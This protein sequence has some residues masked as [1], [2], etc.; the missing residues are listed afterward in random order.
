MT[1]PPM[2][3]STQRDMQAASQARQAAQARL[4]ESLIGACQDL[5]RQLQSCPE[6]ASLWSPAL[7]TSAGHRQV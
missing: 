4:H 5:L 3:C 2:S 7:V 6:L 1:I